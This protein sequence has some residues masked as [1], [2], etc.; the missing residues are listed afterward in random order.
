MWNISPAVFAVGNEYQ[1]MFPTKKECTMKVKI[2][3]RFYYDAANGIMRSSA[4]VHKVTAP[5]EVLDQAKSYTFHLQLLKK[6][7]SISKKNSTRNGQHF[8]VMM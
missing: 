1:I 4:L 5:M 2:G 6:N 8:F 7:H 3:D